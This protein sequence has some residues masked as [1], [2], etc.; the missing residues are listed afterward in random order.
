MAAPN[1]QQFSSLGDLFASRRN[2]ILLAWR[3]ADRA[4]PD[5]TTGRSLTSGQFLDHIPE[6]L[7]AFESRLRSCPGGSDAQ[8]ADDRKKEE[9]VKHGLH[10]WQQGYRLRELINECGHLQFCLVEQLAKI[11]AK[12]PE[13]EARTLLEANRQIMALVNETI[14]ESAGQYERMQQAESAGHVGD[15]MG[16][17]ASVS[18]LE[19]RRATL[20]HQAVHDLNGD[21]LGVRIAAKLL[22]RTDV[23]A[24][25]RVEFATLLQ[26]GVQSLTVTLEELMELARLEAGQEQRKIATFDADAL[27]TQLCDINQPL[28]GERGLFL[29]SDGPVPLTAEGDAEK[30]RRLLKNLLMNALKYTERGGVTV[31]WGV[32]KENWWTMIKDTGP[33]ML[34]GPG[35]PLLAGLQE[36]TA[37]ARESDEKS[38]A[39]EGDVSHVLA[40]PRESAG[41]NGASH[42]QPGEGIGISIVKRLC[43]LLDASLEIASSA[44]T[45]TTFR[46]V[47][48]LH[49]R[50]PPKATRTIPEA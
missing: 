48:P 14:S 12:H 31:S 34:A 43:E 33:G 13:F 35:A 39:I 44:E 7:D 8:V 42:Q 16:A 27:I 19:R 6:I 5:Q 9:G 40:Q 50:R 32:E 26:Q 4:D 15:L 29:K 30:V 18:E 28:A 37:S 2:E 22:G 21:F 46:V 17:L 11:A 45:G 41:A 36:A 38:A 1:N 25:D 23:V 20:I 10:R 49:Y 47:F 3:Q 24:T